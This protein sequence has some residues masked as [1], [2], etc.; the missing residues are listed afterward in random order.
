MDTLP[1]S[2]SAIKVPIPNSS[3]RELGYFKSAPIA[4]YLQSH[5][6]FSGSGSRRNSI[7]NNPTSLKRRSFASSV[8]FKEIP[9][10]ANPPSPAPV[11]KRAAS[12]YATALIDVAQ[13]S[14]SLAEVKKDVQRLSKWLQNVEFYEILVDPLL[15]KKEREQVVKDMAKKGKFHRHIVAVLKILTEKNKFGMVREVLD[16]FKR[17]YGELTRIQMVPAQSVAIC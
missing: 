6:L 1:S 17:I 3:C 9:I 10:D 13:C 15:G 14:S 5:N 12:G 4:S 2:V 7:S 11:H 16:E 8:P